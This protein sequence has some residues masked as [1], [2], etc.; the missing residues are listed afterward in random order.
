VLI[1]RP[2]ATATHGYGRH[3]PKWLRIVGICVFGAITAAIAVLAT[4]W[5]FSQ[6][7]MTRALEEATSRP[8][9]IG[10]F[11]QSYFPPGCMA[12]NIRVLHNGHRDAPPLITID[13]L[14]V[15]GSLPGMFTSP[16]RLAEV[17]LVGMHLRI[18]PKGPHGEGGNSVALNGGKGGKSLAISKV[19]ADGALLE[20]ARSEPGKKAYTLRVDGLVIKDVGAGEPMVYRAILT[21]SEPPGTIRAEGKFGPWKPEDVAATPVS[22]D[23]TY[24]DVNLGVFEGIAGKLQAKG[25]FHG[26]LSHIQTEGTTEVPNFHV[27]GSGSTVR[28]TVGFH[29]IVNGTNG[30]TYLEPAEAHFLR[31]GAIA[32][33]SVEGRQGEKGK[34]TTLAI[35]IPNGR[36]DDLLRLFVEDKTAPMSGALSLEAKVLWPPGPPK[37]LEKIRVDIDFG[38]DRGKF[39][40]QSTQDSIDRISKSA[41]G[42]SKKAEDEDPR[43]MLSDLRA[44]MR[45]SATGW[46]RSAMSLLPCRALPR[47]CT[48]L[49]AY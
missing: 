2:P 6:D 35:S 17:K 36:I 4:H 8:V 32:R 5:P 28:M 10:A 23:F 7:A 44:A 47:R 20:F 49:T 27:S 9:E 46:R 30:D 37:F 19:V 15:V 25:K 31:T 34:T 41:Q 45:R 21:N 42:E 13:K 18:P 11:H 40:S 26:P 43:T 29:A 22:G 33:G 14:L 12:E 16:T 48:G 1:E 39:H 38:I 3:V 24:T